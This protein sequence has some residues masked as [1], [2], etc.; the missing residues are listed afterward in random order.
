MSKCNSTTKRIKDK[1]RS[2]INTDKNGNIIKD[3]DKYP[4]SNLNKK[5]VTITLFDPN[6]VKS[7]HHK[8]LYSKVNI[9][10]T[11]DG[12]KFNSKDSNICLSHR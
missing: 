12:D 9:I 5:S 4:N 3:S 6:K 7:F 2:D 10:S 1:I 11:Y 8:E